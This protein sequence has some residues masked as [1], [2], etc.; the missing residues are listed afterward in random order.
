LISFF[1]SRGCFV[2]DDEW[3]KI[4]EGR[5]APSWQMSAEQWGNKSRCTDPQA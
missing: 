3:M 4:A 2:S 5:L 1:T